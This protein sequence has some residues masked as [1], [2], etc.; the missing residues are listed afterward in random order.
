LIWDGMEGSLNQDTVSLDWYVRVVK[1]LTSEIAIVS[2]GG[3]RSLPGGRMAGGFVS[4][5]PRIHV[6]VLFSFSCR[7]NGL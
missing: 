1:P 7:G 2:S 3:A 6:F 4:L 5:E